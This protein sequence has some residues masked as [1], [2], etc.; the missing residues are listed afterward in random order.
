[1]ELL[2]HGTTLTV[3]NIKL[4]YF[5]T[6]GFDLND[7]SLL[8]YNSIRIYRIITEDRPMLLEGITTKNDIIMLIDFFLE[9]TGPDN[10]F[11][12]KEMYHLI[13]IFRKW[14]NIDK[15]KENTVE[16]IIKKLF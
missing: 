3:L 15:S 11:T 9:L 6:K 5:L 16:N 10:Y 14:R 1:M 8:E 7:A 12:G 2:D 13:H 4:N